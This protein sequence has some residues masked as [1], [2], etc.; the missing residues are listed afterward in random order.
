MSKQKRTKKYHPRRAAQTGGLRAI[1][2]YQPIQADIARDFAL[3]A[4]L[5][6]EAVMSGKGDDQGLHTIVGLLEL[7]DTM[8][9][10]GLGSDCRPAIADAMRSVINARQ[11]WELTGKSE[12]DEHGI[13]AVQNVLSIYDIQVGLATK[14]QVDDAIKIT[15]EKINSGQILLAADEPDLA[16]QAAMK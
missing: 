11:A 7:V 2:W 9:I 10:A 8:A 14:K 1:H 12:L 6:L 5:S 13:K 16:S 15:L 3:S 4:R